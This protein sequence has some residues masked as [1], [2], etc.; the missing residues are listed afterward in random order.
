[1]G[2]I[3]VN[4]D[5]IEHQIQQME[6]ISRALGTL[7]ADINEI[8]NG[9]SWNITSRGLIRQK[10]KMYGNYTEQLGNRTRTMAQGL[11]TAYERYREVEKRNQTNQTNQTGQ[12]NTSDNNAEKTGDWISKITAVKF[13]PRV[14]QPP[15]GPGAIIQKW[16]KI[17]LWMIGLP[18]G[19][20]LK[21]SFKLTGDL[22]GGK[23]VNSKKATWKPE[24]GEAE[25]A[26]GK[27]ASGYLAEGKVEGSIGK[28]SGSGTVQVGTGAVSGEMNATLFK[29][30]KFSPKVGAKASGEVAAVRGEIKGQSG[31]DQYNAHAKA[32]GSLLKAKAEASVGAGKITYEDKSGV[33]HSGIGVEAKAG[34]EAYVAEGKVSGGFTIAGIKVDASVSGKA[35]GAGAKAGGYVTTGGISGEI[36]LGLGLGAGVTISVDWSDFDWNELRKKYKI[37]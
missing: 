20:Q 17:P 37:W 18:W 12:V 30:G 3:R 21:P 24:K 35:G 10:L 31:T 4:T 14:F 28:Y 2:K 22:I 32:E 6:N 13:D 29:N 26:V 36:G 1:M 7:S 8:N 27:K 15:L 5:V 34:A 11:N 16:F 25:I 9:L 33:S 23:V 19:A